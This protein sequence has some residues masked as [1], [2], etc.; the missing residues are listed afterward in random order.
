MSRPRFGCVLYQE[1]WG[2]GARLPGLRPTAAASWRRAPDCG[3]RTARSRRGTIFKIRASHLAAFSADL[4]R[5]FEERLLTD[6]GSRYPRI[7]A[8]APEVAR[9]RIRDGIDRAL[10]YGLRD[11]REAA[12]YVALTF[13]WGEGFES[14]PEFGP[15]AATLRE[16]GVPGWIKIQW[17]EQ[18]LRARHPTPPPGNGPIEAR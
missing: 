15:V 3:W 7:V 17:I 10:S 5:R 18:Y 9:R 14:R 8:E 6:L 2:S 4:R 11:E 16:R 12:A 13:E 1:M